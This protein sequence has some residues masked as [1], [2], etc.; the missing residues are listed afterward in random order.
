MG[1]CE[2]SAEIVFTGATSNVS[3]QLSMI[4]DKLSLQDNR[5]ETLTG[6]MQQL[7]L[8]QNATAETANALVVELDHVIQR[9]RPEQQATNENAKTI[10]E[11]VEGQPKEKRQKSQLHSA[12]TSQLYSARFEL[13][14]RVANLRRAQEMQWHQ[15]HQ[16]MVCVET[17]RV[18]T[19][20]GIAD[21]NG[22][23]GGTRTRG[24]TK[25]R[26]TG[27]ARFSPRN[28]AIVK[29]VIRRAQYLQQWK[30]RCGMLWASR[31]LSA[32]PSKN[33]RSLTSIDLKT[34]RNHCAGG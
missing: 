34:T 11:Q 12:Q 17:R 14:D 13:A 8:R 1:M 29:D 9:L 31:Q 32:H 18:T 7:N 22:K 5:M 28:G 16:E 26:Q 25:S 19:D 33:H 20:S 23:T 15:L 24:R 30:I 6:A 4:V 2:T 10:G 21:K 27:A 3:V